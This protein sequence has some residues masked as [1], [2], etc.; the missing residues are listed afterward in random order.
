ME[1]NVTCVKPQRV[2]ELS[3]KLGNMNN[4]LQGKDSAID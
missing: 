1:R 4:I 2:I 3:D